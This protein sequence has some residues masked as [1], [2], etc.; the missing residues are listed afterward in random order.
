M[1]VRMC[2]LLLL[3]SK[4]KKRKAGRPVAGR[5][6]TLPCVGPA[7]GAAAASYAACFTLCAAQS[8][9]A[10]GFGFLAAYHG[11]GSVQVFIRMPKR[12]LQTGIRKQAITSWCSI[13]LARLGRRA[14]HLC[15]L[16]NEH[17]PTIV[18][19]YWPRLMSHEP[20]P[21]LLKC[22]TQTSLLFGPIWLH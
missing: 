5:D 17:H 18:L 7:P 10:G 22:N 13:S 12:K 1:H 16:C 9:I 20:G 19:M 4:E 14:L 15:S 11:L 3:L 21:T 2:L 8:P 6:P